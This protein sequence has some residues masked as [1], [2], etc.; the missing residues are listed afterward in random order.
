MRVMMSNREE[1]DG[2]RRES[3]VSRSRSGDF[4]TASLPLFLA[5]LASNIGLRRAGADSSSSLARSLRGCSDNFCFSIRR[6]SLWLVSWPVPSIHG[7]RST[8]VDRGRQ[9]RHAVGRY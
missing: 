9:I 1:R 2:G 8:E 3:E 5:E 4:A 6:S 7:L